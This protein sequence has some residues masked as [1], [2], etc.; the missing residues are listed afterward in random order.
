MASL[1]LSLG[2]ADSA[3]YGEQ[4]RMTWSIK[5][6]YLIQHL[7]KFRKIKYIITNI[8]NIGKE[9]FKTNLYLFELYD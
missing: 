7:K 1:F 5:L 4:N 9:E 2:R 3:K 6:V 8:E